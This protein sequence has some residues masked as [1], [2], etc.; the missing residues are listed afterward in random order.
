ME[1]RVGSCMLGVVGEEGTVSQRRWCVAW[2]LRTQAEEIQDQRQRVLNIPLMGGKE[3]Q[4][5]LP[6]SLETW[7]SH[8][9][10]WKLGRGQCRGF[11]HLSKEIRQCREFAM[12]SWKLGS[13]EWL[14]RFLGLLGTQAPELIIIMAPV[15]LFQLLG[16]QLYPHF[17][18]LPPSFFP[19]FLV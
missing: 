18:S 12:G 10:P 16:A 17:P 19:T 5:L 2:V 7:T 4:C 6:G 13:T 1:T 3:S 9:C 15:T 11:S 14:I 8:R